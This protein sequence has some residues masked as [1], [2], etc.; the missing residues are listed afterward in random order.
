[1]RQRVYFEALKRHIPEIEIVLGHF[2]THKKKMYLADQRD[3]TVLGTK[4]VFVT[5]TEEKGSDVNLAVT[6]VNDAW[7]NSMD[8]GVILSNDSDLTEAF[9][10]AH[11]ERH[12]DIILLTP[13]RFKNK[14]SKQLKKYSRMAIS[15]KAA[16]LESSQ[17]PDP[18]PGT[19]LRRPQSW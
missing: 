19:G 6:L 4:T 2:L 9:R 7:A 10:I 12:K 18:I 13:P 11:V 3:V 5:N 16:I 8:C 15:L 1:M 17:L 14:R